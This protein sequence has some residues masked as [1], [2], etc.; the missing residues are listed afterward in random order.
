[1]NSATLSVEELISLGKTNYSQ[2]RYDVA[3]DYLKAALFRSQPPS[4]DILDYLA[5]VCD[6]MGRIEDSLQYGKKMILLDDINARVSQSR[7]LERNN[8]E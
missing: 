1:M 2:K 5:A 3:L 6:K 7:S 8:T 4:M